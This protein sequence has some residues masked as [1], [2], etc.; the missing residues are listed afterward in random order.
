MAQMTVEEF[1]K[2]LQSETGMV[3]HWRT[4]AKDLVKK[5]EDGASAA[6]YKNMIKGKTRR[7]TYRAI[8]RLTGYP[9]SRSTAARSAARPAAARMTRTGWAC[10]S[11]PAKKRFTT[12]AI[13]G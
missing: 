11:C 9:R 3:F 7:N 13:P 5:K 6:R 1:A 8:Y 10:T 4:I 2:K 12:A